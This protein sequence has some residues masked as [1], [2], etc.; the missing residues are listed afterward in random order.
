MT[1]SAHNCKSN[2]K[3]VENFTNHKTLFINFIKYKSLSSY[4]EYQNL[5]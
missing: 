2:L 5:T 3:I 4:K 1:P